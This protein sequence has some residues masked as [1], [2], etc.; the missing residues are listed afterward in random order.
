M[1]NKDA[2]TPLVSV[3]LPVYNGGRFIA[4]AIDSIVAQTYTNWELIIIDD[5]STDNTITII[6]TYSDGRI[7]LLRNSQNSK[8]VYS[9][10]K[11]IAAATGVYIARM[12]ADDICL[13]ARFEKQVDFLENHKDYDVVDCLQEYID[14]EG[15]PTGDFNFSIFSHDAI[16]G[17]LQRY[18]CLGHSSIMARRSALAAFKYRQIV[19]EDYDLW[20]RMI[21]HG[22]RFQKLEQPLLLYRIHVESITGTAKENN[23]LFRHIADT[24]WFYYRQLSLSEKLSPFNLRVLLSMLGDYTTWQKKR[25]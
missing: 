20:L 4:K 1:T 7:K 16:Y 2:A 19:F 5:A 25:L 22:S 13:P 9:L 18:N 24:K 12:D 21:A 11:G 3:V 15:K 8:I 6:N 17:A 23:L 10:N 14:E